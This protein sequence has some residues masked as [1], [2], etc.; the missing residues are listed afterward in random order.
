MAARKKVN[1]S[2]LVKT[3]R[4]G[5]GCQRLAKR[6]GIDS[7]RLRRI[8]VSHGVVMPSPGSP[9]SMRKNGRWA[10]R[11]DRCRVCGTQ[12][13]PHS[14]WGKCNR[15]YGRHYAYVKKHGLDWGIVKKNTDERRKDGLD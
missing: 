4:E 6:V 11:H 12:D 15:C 13:M 1:E 9:P 5:V 7:L 3:Y 14:G 10:V 2:E 8:L